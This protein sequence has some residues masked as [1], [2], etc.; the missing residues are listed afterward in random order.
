MVDEWAHQ[1]G[2][3]SFSWSDQRG[4][5]LLFSIRAVP[6]FLKHGIVTPIY[7]KGN[8]K[9]PTNYR[10]I[11]VTPI[12]LTLIEHTINKRQQPIVERTP[13]KRRSDF[14]QGTFS[15]HSAMILS[16]CILESKSNKKHMFLATLG[17]NF[18]NHD[19][20]PSSKS[21]PWWCNWWWLGPRLL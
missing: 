14:T 9:L 7:N 20:D 2:K 3:T 13:S 21:I 6:D 15:L 12:L 11:T 18:V 8:Q 1:A 10:G 19:R 5:Q 17:L 4:H 16:E